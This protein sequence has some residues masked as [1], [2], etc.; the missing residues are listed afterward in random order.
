MRTANSG[1]RA[2]AYRVT[3]PPANGAVTLTTLKE[4]LRI[5]ND[6]QDTIL[7]LYLDAAIHFAEDCTGLAL[8]TQ[9]YE[10]ERDFFPNTSSEAYYLDGAMP[11]TFNATTGNVGFELRRGPVQSVESLEYVQLNTAATYTTVD[12]TL[13]YVVNPEAGKL[14]NLLLA[15]E[16]TWPTDAISPRPSA[17]RITFVVGFGDNDT[18]VPADIRLAILEHATQMFANRGDCASDSC[19]GLLPAISKGIYNKH[20]VVNL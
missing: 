12:P 19:A 16:Q 10:T 2:Y 9:T 14:A 11:E 15:P 6:R 7:Q 17:I 5:T 13:Y 4:H 20:K 3:V 18:D 8:I 1:I